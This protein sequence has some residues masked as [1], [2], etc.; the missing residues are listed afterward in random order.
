MNHKYILKTSL[1]LV[2]ILLI[3]SNSYAQ[4]PNDL[5]KLAE[6]TWAIILKELSREDVSFEKKMA[7][8]NEFIA[9]SPEKSKAHIE[10]K[11]MLEKI[12]N[13][14]ARFYHFL[15]RDSYINKTEWFSLG[16]VGGNYGLGFTTSFATF[17][18]K[19]FFW[20]SMRF[21]FT[22][23]RDVGFVAINAKTMIGIPF[24]WGFANQ[25]EMRIS[26][27]ITAGHSRNTFMFLN[28]DNGE[29]SIN[30]NL[31]VPIEISYVFHAYKDS[32]FQIGVILDMPVVFYFYNKG[33]YLP[34]LS[35]FIGFRI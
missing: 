28:S 10:A 23:L 27:G 12:E 20:E 24:F 35:G 34:S 4:E 26:S 14:E 19:R 17:R 29:N 13:S 18:W 2:A 30:T 15:N 25:H 5:E 33:S 21:Q 32:A 22:M 11:T 9:K 1:F 8:I 3:F 31:S 7:I 16:F 6:E